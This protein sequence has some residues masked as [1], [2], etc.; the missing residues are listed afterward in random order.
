MAANLPPALA[1][2][3]GLRTLLKRNPAVLDVIGLLPLQAAEGE[4][5]SADDLQDLLRRRGSVAGRSEIVQ[6]FKLLQAAE[7]GAFIVGR[8]TYPSR[9]EWAKALAEVAPGPVSEPH[10][11]EKGSDNASLDHQFRLRPDYVVNVRLPK[12]LTPTEAARLSE[13]IKTLPFG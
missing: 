1:S 6:V 2:V 5:T 8:R 11:S 4:S 9:F 10:S 3:R 12:D 7:Y 13:Y